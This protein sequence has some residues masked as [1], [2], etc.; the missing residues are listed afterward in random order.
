MLDVLHGDVWSDENVT[1]RLRNLLE[2]FHPEYAGKLEVG[3][4]NVDDSVPTDNLDTAVT[5]LVIVN[6]FLQELI[7]TTGAQVGHSETFSTILLYRYNMRL[8]LG[9]KSENGWFKALLFLSFQDFVFKL[10]VG[11]LGQLQLRLHLGYLSLH[12]APRFLDGD[13]AI[14]LLVLKICFMFVGS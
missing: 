2:Q 11:C 12:F 7:V 6:G 4:F 13:Q 14:F 1:F 9:F 5:V 8:V 10:Y 3:S